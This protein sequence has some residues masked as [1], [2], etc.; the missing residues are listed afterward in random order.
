METLN[1][2][3]D[4][5]LASALTQHVGGNGE[6]ADETADIADADPSR[7]MLQRMCFRVGDLGL[8][9]PVTA[10]REVI[11]PP[12]VSRIPNAASWLRGLANVRGTLV[13]V[14]DTATALEVARTADAPLYL[15]IFG[16][17]ETAVGLLIESLPRLLDIDVSGA[18]LDRPVVPPLL[19]DSII[20]TYEHGGRFWLDID[21]DILFDTLG[22]HVAPVHDKR[23]A[24]ERTAGAN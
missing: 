1:P 6:P 20:A 14:V 12:A 7:Q 5:T 19:G 9:F 3:D 10:G 21:L 4:S 13:P 8:L 22:R 15:L 23:H 18:V 24:S 17:G 11:T 2:R 16:H